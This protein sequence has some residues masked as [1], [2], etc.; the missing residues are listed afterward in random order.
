MK[1]YAETAQEWNEKAPT[2]T[3]VI[4]LLD[5]SQKATITKTRSE[6]WDMCGSACVLLDGVSGGYA[7]SHV[8]V[9]EESGI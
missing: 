9:I 2:G 7:L 4:V 1:C 6:A 3:D 5:G 8:Y